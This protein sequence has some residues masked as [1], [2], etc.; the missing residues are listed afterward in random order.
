MKPHMREYVT[1]IPQDSKKRKEIWVTFENGMY[2][3]WTK[4]IHKKTPPL[5]LIS[6]VSPIKIDV[7]NGTPKVTAVTPSL[8]DVCYQFLRNELKYAFEGLPITNK[9]LTSILIYGKQ[10][11]NMHLFQHGAKTHGILPGDIHEAITLLTQTLEEII[12]AAREAAGLQLLAKQERIKVKLKERFEDVNT[13]TMIHGTGYA[14]MD[15][16]DVTRV[17][18]IEIYKSE[19]DE[20]INS[21]M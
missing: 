15:S 5:L 4:F 12:F 20:L 10:Y 7:Y 14:K 6:S 2:H 11:G 21:L 17:D 16:E 1:Y 8:S 3:C 19:D 18:P 13:D 9:M